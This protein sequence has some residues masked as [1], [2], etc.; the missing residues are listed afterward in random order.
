MVRSFKFLL[1]ITGSKTIAYFKRVSH[2]LD[3]TRT[4]VKLKY[5]PTHKAYAGTVTLRGYIFFFLLLKLASENVY[6]YNKQ[7][8]FNIYKCQRSHFLKASYSSYLFSSLF[9][10]SKKNNNKKQSTELIKMVRLS[11]T[12]AVITTFFTLA[13]SER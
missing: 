12:A 4:H 6:Y 10:L 1:L 3:V 2:G 5:C 8:K 9:L 13:L 7:I 11:L